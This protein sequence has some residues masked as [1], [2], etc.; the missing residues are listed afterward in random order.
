MLDK[1]EKRLVVALQIDELL[2]G[3]PHLQGWLRE[4]GDI[5]F[6]SRGG[7]I[8]LQITHHDRANSLEAVPENL[9]LEIIGVARTLLPE[10][11]ELF[12]YTAHELFCWLP[13]M[14]L[15]AADAFALHLIHNL[16]IQNRSW[17]EKTFLHSVTRAVTPAEIITSTCTVMVQEAAGKPLSNTE[18]V[19]LQQ[20]YDE[21]LDAAIMPLRLHGRESVIESIARYLN[22]PAVEPKLAII[23]GDQQTGIMHFLTS[24][25]M[26]FNGD[27][28][29]VT[30]LI[31]QAHHRRS[32]GMVNNLITMLLNTLP[33]S[34]V[35]KLLSSLIAQ[36][37]WLPSFVPALQQSGYR[38]SDIVPKQK[39]LHNGICKVIIALCEQ[40]CQ[41][42]IID[43]LPLAD[44]E[45]LDI[46][47]NVLKSLKIGLRV[48][49]GCN[50]DN[51]RT[52]MQHF[53]GTEHCLF[54]LYSF[55]P[56]EV[57]SYLEALTPDSALRSQASSLYSQTQGLLEKMENCLHAWE[58]EGRIVF[59]EGAWR[60]VALTTPSKNESLDSKQMVQTTK[61]PLLSKSKWLI[62]GVVFLLLL[63]TFSLLRVL[64]PVK[65]SAAK[66][67]LQINT[68][69]NWIDGADMVLVP[70]G[71]YSLG[72]SN[73]MREKLLKMD[74]NWHA[75]SL[76]AEGPERII[77]N[78][79]YWIY[80]YEVTVAQYRTF[81]RVTGR[82]APSGESSKPITAISWT[83]ANAY[84]QWAGGHLPTEVEWEIAARGSDDRLYPWG[85]EVKQNVT[86]LAACGSNKWDVSPFQAY[87]FAG[88]VAEWCQN[89]YSASNDTL[90]VVR[91]GSYR[92]S[93]F[94][95]SSR[96]TH[97]QGFIP[98]TRDSSIGF[99]CV[100]P[101]REQIIEE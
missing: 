40:Q 70:A 56:E 43:R 24:L 100:L 69:V 57:V 75:K 37:P 14:P 58:Q 59:R 7:L 49:A 101:H 25:P 10:E 47:A 77:N 48:I 30:K 62:L 68:K 17:R 95:Y 26:L 50:A 94:A 39:E 4:Q 88:N 16:Q 15:V 98:D 8:L 6:P 61:T 28:R 86:T 44:T 80:R 29:P 36:Y 71:S 31:C 72:L 87:D 41:L 55:T 5:H 79:P 54:K 27:E 32:F 33:H 45:S 78:S 76:A 13:E 96:T 51:L 35:S 83:E 65:N 20:T 46:L 42:V 85:N 19:N 90:R 60:W 81:C 52:T 99:R 97:R 21:S 92:S 34:E 64:Q 89:G 38:V 67:P 93:D 66:P 22:L 53:V 18:I 11:A 1:D 9:M 73:S 82:P 63:S 84:C 23:V 2:S 91:G 74:P 12:T 3:L